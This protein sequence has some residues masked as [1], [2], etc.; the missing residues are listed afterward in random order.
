MPDSEVVEQPLQPL[1][2]RCRPKNLGN[3]LVR[4][5]DFSGDFFREVPANSSQTLNERDS[6]IERGLWVDVFEDTLCPRMA[7]IA[8]QN[9]FTGF[10]FLP[11][12][13]SRPGAEESTLKRNVS[14]RIHLGELPEQ[15]P[16]SL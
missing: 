7:H 8:G 4:P 15:S 2:R 16:Q 13:G 11:V 14:G 1:L 10:S 3:F 9:F 6:R 5:S 12:Q